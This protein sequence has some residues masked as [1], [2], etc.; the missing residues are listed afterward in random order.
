MPVE[1]NSDD[2]DAKFSDGMLEIKLSKIE[3]KEEKERI[4]R[5]S[6]NSLA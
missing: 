4:I 6:N 2:V 1:V 5:I 3:P